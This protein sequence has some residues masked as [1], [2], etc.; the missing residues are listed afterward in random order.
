MALLRRRGM[1]GMTGVLDITSPRM[2]RDAHLLLVPSTVSV[3]DIGE[4]VKARAP[5]GWAG[6]AGCS[7]R[8]R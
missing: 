1:T 5:S 4:L 8:S 2:L 3:H 7:A 6:T